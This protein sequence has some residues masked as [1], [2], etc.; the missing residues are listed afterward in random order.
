M[1]MAKGAKVIAEGMR[2][3]AVGAGRGVTNCKLRMAY[4]ATW[5]AGSGS[6]NQRHK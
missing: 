1:G 4:W 2:H 3:E 6:L 5:K